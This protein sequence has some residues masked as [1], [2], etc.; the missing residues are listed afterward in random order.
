MLHGLDSDLVFWCF[1]SFFLRFATQ[2]VVLVFFGENKVSTL[3]MSV[4]QASAGSPGTSW[5]A[6]DVYLSEPEA[7]VEWRSGRVGWV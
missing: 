6:R 7:G 3:L 5:E 1:G 2:Q 4:Q